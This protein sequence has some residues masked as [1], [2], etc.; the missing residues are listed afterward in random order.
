M[1]KSVCIVTWYKVCNFGAFLQ[2]YALKKILEKEGYSVSFYDYDRKLFPYNKYTIVTRPFSTVIRKLFLKPVR[3]HSNFSNKKQ[4]LFTKEICKHFEIADANKTYDICLVGSDEIFNIENGFNVFQFEPNVHYIRKISYAASF[5]ETTL[6]MLQ[7]YRLTSMIK[8][9]LL[10][11]DGISV[12]DDNSKMLTEK[13][14][15]SKNVPIHIDPVLLY[16]FETELADMKPLVNSKY[17]LFYGYDSHR[18][19]VHRIREIKKFARHKNLKI[20][21]A[22]YY[23]NWC[24][25]NIQC[26]PF[27]FVNY[28]RYANYIITTTFHGSVFSI[29]LNK[30]F[31]MFKQNNT[32]K[33]LS[34]L[35]QFDCQ[36][37]LITRTSS[38]ETVLSDHIDCTSLI[39]N[40]RNK[41]NHY[42]GVFLHE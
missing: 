26:T 16:G 19:P 23:H 4:Q 36:N 10:S 6:S 8:K 12:R 40:E 35:K 39:V 27:E 15:G 42:L 7:F 34:L 31:C 5:G 13:L 29:L 2:A 32:N 41:A 9:G 3:R 25:K 1:K 38:I 37:A 20:I 22:G 14:T 33:V 24:D 28:M 17:L 18:I 30:K 11:F 21:S